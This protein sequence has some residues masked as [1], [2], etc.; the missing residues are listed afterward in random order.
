M[1]NQSGGK[2]S[3]PVSDVTSAAERRGEQIVQAQC[4]KCHQTG[5]SGAPRVGD[6][7]AWIQRL[8]RGLDF[9]VRSAINGHGPMPPR[10]GM[11]SLTD[12]EIR[13]AVIYMFNP[14][15]APPAASADAPAAKP[16]PNHRVIGGTEIFLGVVAADAMRGQYAKASKER[17]MHGGIPSGRNHYHVNISL[18]D[19]TTRGV[20][21]DAQ[22]EAS[23]ANPVSGSVTK[24]LELVTLN[25]IKSYGNYFRMPGKDAYTITVK[26]R[27][28]GAARTIEATFAFRHD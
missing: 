13:A 23:V 3:E 27:R 21:S 22:V 15:P 14:A 8:R 7:A 28:P 24:K 12:S 4:A 26:I 19:S 10:G 17:S 25:S 6:R 5:V 1:V 2:W 20:I 11:A 18:F 9:V 16:D